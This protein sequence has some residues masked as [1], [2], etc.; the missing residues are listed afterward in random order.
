M[1]RKLP[2]RKEPK[3]HVHRYIVAVSKRVIAKNKKSSHVHT[4]F[5]YCVNLKEVMQ[6]CKAMKKGQWA[7]VYSA[8]HNFIQ[9]Y[10]QE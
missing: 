10:A 1:L 8:F 2:V 6:K 7:E 9:G 4:K 5:Y 3:L